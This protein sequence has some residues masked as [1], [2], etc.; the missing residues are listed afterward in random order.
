MKPIHFAS[1]V[2]TAR[3]KKYNPL[4]QAVCALMLSMMQFRSYLLPQ[5]FTII[6]IKDTFPYARQRASTFARISK[7]VSRLQEFEF[8]V[9]TEH[10]T[11]ASRADILTH[12]VFERKVKI[13]KPPSSKEEITHI[14]NAYTLPFDGAFKRA[15]GRAAASIVITD[16]LGNKLHQEGMHLPEAKYNNEVEYATLIKGLEKCIDLGTPK[17]M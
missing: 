5:K 1:R 11:R 12:R 13:P 4:E 17:N 9:T 15:L 6:S 7:W 8:T 14:E 2:M 16:P 3:E 10:T